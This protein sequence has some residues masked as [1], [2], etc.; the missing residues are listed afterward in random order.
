MFAVIKH[1]KC[2]VLWYKYTL[3]NFRLQVSVNCRFRVI[4]CGDTY[5]DWS[6]YLHLPEVEEVSKIHSIAVHHIY[7]L[8]SGF[9]GGRRQGSRNMKSIFTGRGRGGG[10]GAVVPFPPQIRCYTCIHNAVILL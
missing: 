10:R 9:S 3:I 1:S 8:N 7:H 4:I 2:S 5:I 6:H